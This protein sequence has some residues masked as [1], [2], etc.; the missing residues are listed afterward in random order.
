MGEKP[1]D[2]SDSKVNRR[3]FLQKGAVVAAGSAALR[4]T[5]LSYSR[6]AGA[7]DSISLGLI[8]VGNRESELDGIVASLKDQKNV[9]MTAICDLWTH[10]VERAVAANQKYYGKAPRA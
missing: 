6:I 4:S 9:E 5:A 3:E 10:N 8:G 7:N 2:S 1:M